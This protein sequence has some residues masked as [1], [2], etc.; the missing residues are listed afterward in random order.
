M[1]SEFARGFDRDPLLIGDEELGGYA[2]KEIGRKPQLANL[3]ELS[4]FGYHAVHTGPTGI[5][6]QALHVP[7]DAAGSKRL[8][9]TGTPSRRNS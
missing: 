2:C 6:L 4:D 7:A 1:A 3:L 8:N 5:M 9:A